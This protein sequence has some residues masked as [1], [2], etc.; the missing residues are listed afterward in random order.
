MGKESENVPAMNIASALATKRGWDHDVMSD[1][2]MF[3]VLPSGQSRFGYGAE[4]LFSPDYAACTMTLRRENEMIVE[5]IGEV[6][7]VIVSVNKVVAPA[8]F[9]LTD[10]YGHSLFYQLEI[11]FSETGVSADLLEA[12]ADE[13]VSRLDF[14][15]LATMLANMG[16]KSAEE[17]VAC[18]EDK[19][20]RIQ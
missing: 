8:R 5:R 20:G 17:A 13:A 15:S 19:L 10:E 6:Q 2:S 16:N 12:K 3:L 11:V 1:H 7:N 18:V 9:S 4:F 14:C